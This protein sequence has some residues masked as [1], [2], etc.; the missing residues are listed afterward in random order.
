MEA[1]FEVA[2]ETESVTEGTVE[3][4]IDEDWDSDSV[5]EN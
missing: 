1:E 5:T 3:A 4:E 2:V